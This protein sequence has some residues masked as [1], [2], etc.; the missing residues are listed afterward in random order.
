MDDLYPKR[1]EME[2]PDLH[3]RI[4]INKKISLQRSMLFKVFGSKGNPGS[5]FK[6]FFD[7]MMKTLVSVTHDDRHYQST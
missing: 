1:T 3:E 4:K 6:G 7:K 5:M 2:V